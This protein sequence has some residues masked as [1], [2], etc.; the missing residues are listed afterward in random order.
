[1]NR[2]PIRGQTIHFSFNDGPMAKKTSS[3]SSMQRGR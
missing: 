1:M 3:T 2:D